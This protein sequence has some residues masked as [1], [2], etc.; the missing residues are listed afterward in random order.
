M[1]EI[2]EEIL[3]WSY[4]LDL[5]AVAKLEEDE[6]EERKTNYTYLYSQRKELFL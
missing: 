4:V 1:I 5:I 3:I 2:F 6:E